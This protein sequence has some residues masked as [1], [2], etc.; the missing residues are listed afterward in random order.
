MPGDT[1][2]GSFCWNISDTLEFGLPCEWTMRIDTEFPKGDFFRPWYDKQYRRIIE[3]RNGSF[4]R[5][6]VTGRIRSGTI[7]PEK[8]K[9]GVDVREDFSFI[10]PEDMAYGEFDVKM[11]V[12]RATYLPNR[13]LSD[14]LR[15]ND[16]LSGPVVGRILIGKGK[17]EEN[18]LF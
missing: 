16:S 7:S 8:W 12:N 3:R 14:Y 2:S 6:T 4:Y 13:R 17:R 1:V 10:L 5:H 18:A 15:N 11:I 9:I